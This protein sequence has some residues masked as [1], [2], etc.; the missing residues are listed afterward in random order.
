[1]KTHFRGKLRCIRICSLAILMLFSTSLLSVEAR[2]KVTVSIEKT[3]TSL[4]EVFNQVE[5]S[6]N[7]LFSYNPAILAGLKVSNSIAFEGNIKDFLDQVL[8]GSN[9]TY[10][11][12][13]NE[14]LLQ[15]AKPKTTQQKQSNRRTIKGTVISSE[16]NQPIIGANIWI[17]NSAT[18]AIT[19]NTPA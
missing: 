17:K 15:S 14:I 5:A 3:N 11:V 10:V 4:V 19:F 18:G 12:K 6:S 2:D 7:Y 8:S 13:E 9:I 16:D 1:M